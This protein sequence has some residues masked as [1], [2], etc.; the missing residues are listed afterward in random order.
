MI[1]PTRPQAIT[2]ERTAGVMVVAWL[3]G[4][5][6]EYPLVW[7]R[8]HCPCAT[9][10]EERRDAVLA[11]DP[12]RL[13]ATPLPSTEIIGAEFVGNYAIRLTW[14]DG[15]GAG[16]FPFVALRTSCPCAACNPEGA[17]PLVID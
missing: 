15:H 3:D 2:I 8:A 5:R 1:T 7:L 13:T 17:P 9:C 10:R 6:S 11:A 4:H 12:L 16:I 14:S